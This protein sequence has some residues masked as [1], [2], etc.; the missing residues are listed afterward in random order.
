M[1]RTLTIGALSSIILLSMIFGCFLQTPNSSL[2][3]EISEE[4]NTPQPPEENSILHGENRIEDF[5]HTRFIP[6]EAISPI[7]KNKNVGDVNGD[8]KDDL[9]IYLH[10][11]ASSAGKAYLFFGPIKSGDLALTT[12]NVTFVG[13]A[14]TTYS[15]VQIAGNMDINNDSLDDMLIFGSPTSVCVY[16]GRTNWESSYII[17]ESSANATFY[18][19]ATEEFGFDVELANLD[20]DDFADILISARNAP[21]GVINVIYGNDS[22]SGTYNTSEIAYNRIVKDGDLNHKIITGDFNGDAI[23]DIFILKDIE[24][25]YIIYGGNSLK[26]T[27]ILNMTTHANVTFIGTNI[28]SNM[29]I[30]DLNQDSICDLALSEY[31]IGK[32][33]IIFG[34]PQWQGFYNFSV[35]MNISITFPGITRVNTFDITSDNRNDLILHQITT[36]KLHFIRGRIESEWNALNN[37]D[38]SNSAEF[39]LNITNAFDIGYYM[40]GGSD[41]TGDGKNDLMV[42][43]NNNTNEYSYLIPGDYLTRPQATNLQLNPSKTRTYGTE[44]LEGSYVYGDMDGDLENTSAVEI[45]WYK[46]NI[47][48]PSLNGILSVSA[49]NTSAGDEWKFTVLTNDHYENSLLATSPIITIYDNMVPQLTSPSDVLLYEQGSGNITWTI[50]DNSTRT[51]SYVVTMNNTLNLGSGTW[52]NGSQIVQSLTTLQTG[53]FNLKIEALDGIGGVNTDTVIVMILPK[54]AGTNT[55]TTTTGTSTTTDSSTTTTSGS[56]GDGDSTWYEDPYLIGGIVIGTTALLTTVI[57]K[58]KKKPISV[59]APSIP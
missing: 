40:S 59:P 42:S 7:H 24:M 54:S 51:T 36:K 48:Q 45:N 55:T 8:G 57:V 56:S 39:T 47:L 22:I 23:D 33:Q 31:S 30:G 32:I 20:G 13:P 26:E 58:S 18:G 43:S 34:G 19:N 3:N 10:N 1:K 6:E 21:G 2:S 53:T 29:G 17:Q 38:Y 11:L 46:N 25:D 44:N 28:G 4:S 9:I 49:S 52:T 15:A 50:T 16:Y 37:T 5:A 35:Q 41:F 14:P 12:A 27:P